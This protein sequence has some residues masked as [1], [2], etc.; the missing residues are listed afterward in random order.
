[1]STR[2]LKTR[3]AQYE[4]ASWAGENQSGIEPICDRVLVLP[5]RAIDKTRGGIIMTNEVVES[6]SMSATTGVIVAT[7]PAAFSYDSTGFNRWPDDAPKPAPGHRI[8]FRKFA[9]EEYMGRDGTAYRV[10]DYREIGG[11]MG[12]ADNGDDE[13]QAVPGITMSSAAA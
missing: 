7:G 10:M 6:G 5:D 13:I 3:H 1:M 8:C 11:T 2:V 4:M 12:M 9:G